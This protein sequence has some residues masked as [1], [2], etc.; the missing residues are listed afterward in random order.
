MK[1]V[2][3]MQQ[4]GSIAA[5]PN[6]RIGYGIPN[7]KLSFGNLLTEYA[8]SNATVNACNVTI[9]WN[10]K[11]VDAMKYEIERKAPG[12]TNFT[13]VG[14]VNPVPG[15]ILANR[16]YQFI[17]TLSNVSAGIISYRI[18]QI[19]DTSSASFTA[20]YIDTTT[21]S[22]TSGCVTTGTG[23]INGSDVKVFVQPNPSS[24][25]TITLIIETPYA[26]AV[27]PVTVY[28][29]NGSIIKQLNENKGTGKKTIILYLDRL[30][31]GKYYIKV[32]NGQKL[33]GTAE[34]IKL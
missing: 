26:V 14:E 4:A 11:D 7:M 18:K 27:M 32:L 24:G 22:L 16:T 5:T 10:T 9:N 25:N 17:N 34:L 19:I 13:K 29:A 8:T 20:F 23:N 2:R 3:A 1:I 15:K 21:V 12:E 30:S 6:D 33:L 31:K 28:D